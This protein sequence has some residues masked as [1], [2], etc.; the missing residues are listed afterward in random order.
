MKIK[1]Q[2]SQ[3]QEMLQNQQIK[4]FKIRDVEIKCT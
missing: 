1:K 2:C 3:A 4:N